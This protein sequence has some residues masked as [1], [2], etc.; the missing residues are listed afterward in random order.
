MFVKGPQRLHLTILPNEQSTTQL[1]LTKPWGWRCALMWRGRLHWLQMSDKLKR[2]RLKL[3]LFCFLLLNLSPNQRC[4]EWHHMKHFVFPFL[5]VPFGAMLF[6]ECTNVSKGLILMK[7]PFRLSSWTNQHSK[8][9]IL[10]K[11]PQRIE[12]ENTGAASV[13]VYSCSV[14]HAS[15]AVHVL[16]H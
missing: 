12:A 4:L 2:L 15:Q 1:K 14:P 9:S 16:H 13:A 10:L 11:I 5:G 3:V 7:S 8:I 6:W